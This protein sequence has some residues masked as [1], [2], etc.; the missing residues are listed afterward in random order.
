MNSSF[1]LEI[2][3]FAIDDQ[4]T[5]VSV[6]NSHIISNLKFWENVK[7]SNRVSHLFN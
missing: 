7:G 3:G 1:R 2:D 6:Q 4:H 5:P